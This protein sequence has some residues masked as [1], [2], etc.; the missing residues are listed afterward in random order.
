MSR[1]IES[2]VK[3]GLID[4]SFINN[5]VYESVVGSVACGYNTDQSDC[6]VVAVVNIPDEAFS[7]V[8][9]F[10]KI[11]FSIYS[12]KYYTFLLQSG[13]PHLLEGI[14]TEDV[15][16]THK[17]DS[18]DYLRKNRKEFITKTAIN[19]FIKEINFIYNVAVSGYSPKTKE[20]IDL[21]GYDTKHARQTIQLMDYTKQMIVDQDIYLS[22]NSKEYI[23]IQTGMWGSI[24]LFKIEFS[25][26]MDEIHSLLDNC[27]LP[28]NGGFKWL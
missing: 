28:E 20:L 1:Y 23:R 5:I 24:D 27:K 7:K 6:D 12:L 10:N 18:S 14:F 8:F 9:S 16:V 11:D 2:F 21:Y 26:R 13:M 25:K 4:P 15:Y 3:E 19:R 22:Y 17:T